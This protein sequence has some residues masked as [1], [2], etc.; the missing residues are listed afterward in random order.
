M[1][2]KKLLQRANLYEYITLRAFKS[3]LATIFGVVKRFLAITLIF[4][5]SAQCIFKLGIIT[6]FEA[7]R[8]YIAE[9]LCINKEKPITMCYGQCFLDRNLSL[10][11][12]T[13]K[14]TPVKS[15]VKME[16]PI[17]IGSSFDVSLVSRLLII[18]TYSSP[19]SLYKFAADFSFFHPPC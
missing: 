1:L 8:D 17:F 7:N 11:D 13:P 16:A 9:V 19:Q 12:E 5:L 10:A 2:L 14:Q 3:T 4:L 15:T 6:Y 18:E